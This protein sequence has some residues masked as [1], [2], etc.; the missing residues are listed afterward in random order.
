M[1]DRSYEG[2]FSSVYSDDTYGAQIAAQAMHDAGRRHPIS[3]LG[4]RSNPASPDRL[5]GYR[6]VYGDEL[7]DDRV[8]FTGW[9]AT[10]GFSAMMQLLDTHD[11]IDGLLAGSDRIAVGA[12]EAIRQRG[13]TVPDDIAV[14]GS[15]TIQSPGAAIPRLPPCNSRC[16][17]R[18][19]RQPTLPCA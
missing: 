3:I 5:T 15:T 13:L 17:K 6:R 8:L 4:Q 11:D 16:E 1:E 9:D 10:A 2:I 7:P 14:S 18:A 19:P 12:I